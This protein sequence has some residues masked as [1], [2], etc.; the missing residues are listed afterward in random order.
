MPFE[1]RDS[2]WNLCDLIASCSRICVY[3]AIESSVK[4]HEDDDDDHQAC[5]KFRVGSTLDAMRSCNLCVC[6]FD[7]CPARFCHASRPLLAAFELL[8]HLLGAFA[9]FCFFFCNNIMTYY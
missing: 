2:S 1:M 9:L 3:S 8:L 5:A 6:V 7:Q 4:L